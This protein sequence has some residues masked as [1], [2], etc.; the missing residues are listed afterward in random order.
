MLAA[1]CRHQAFRARHGVKLGLSRPRFVR[2]WSRALRQVPEAF[3]ARSSRGGL[4]EQHYHDLGVAVGGER[5]LVVPVIR[6]ADQLGEA[7]IERSIAE[8]AE[9]AT[10]GRLELAANCRAVAS[11]SPTAASVNPFALDADPQPAP[12]RHP[13]A[14]TRSREKARGG[15]RRGRP[16]R[17]RPMFY[18]AVL[19]S[20]DASMVARW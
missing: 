8:L 4:V 11:R 19:R 16:H 5:G 6:D 10:K 13:G 1:A 9:R 14:C 2:R 17:A 12:V 7:A 20:S 18:R 3:N 15:G